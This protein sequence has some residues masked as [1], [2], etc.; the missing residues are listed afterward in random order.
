M[1][2]QCLAFIIGI[3]LTL[4]NGLVY[5]VSSIF[6]ARILNAFFDLESKDPVR[7]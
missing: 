6:L 2:N 3:I 5:P 1:N 4:A 7:V